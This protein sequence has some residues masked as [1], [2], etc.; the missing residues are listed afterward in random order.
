MYNPLFSVTFDMLNAFDT[1]LSACVYIFSRLEFSM[2]RESRAW[3]RC[4]KCSSGVSFP[5]PFLQKWC[6]ACSIFR[7]TFHESL[8]LIHGEVFFE[9]RI[10]WQLQWVKHRH[11]FFSFLMIYSSVLKIEHLFLRNPFIIWIVP[12]LDTVTAAGPALWRRWAPGGAGRGLLCDFIFGNVASVTQTVLQ[13]LEHNNNW[14]LSV[15]RSMSHFRSFT[16]WAAAPHVASRART[17]IGDQVLTSVS[18][19]T[20]E[21]LMENTPG[22][23]EF[24]WRHFETF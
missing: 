9:A 6:I 16:V 15:G 8:R 22:N 18:D 14:M 3:K 7:D 24:L 23:K 13:A 4:T 17:G 11:H 1:P 2:L 10:W 19:F 21:K 20:S 12:P 5:H